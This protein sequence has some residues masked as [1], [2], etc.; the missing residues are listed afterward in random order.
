MFRQ[1]V[2][3]RPEI[4]KFAGALQGQR[5]SKGV[6]IT[7]SNFS[8]EAQEY[9]NMISSKIVLID[10]ERLTSLMVDHNVEVTPMGNYAVKKLDADYFEGE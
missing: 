10:G 1:N 5:A 7:T 6:S 8:R 9:A 3:G 2:V 4:Q